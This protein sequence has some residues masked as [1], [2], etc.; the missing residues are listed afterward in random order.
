MASAP[1]TKILSCSPEALHSRP[2]QESTRTRCSRGEIER[3][4]PD[5]TGFKSDVRRSRRHDLVGSDGGGDH[6]VDLAGVQRVIREGRL[7]R[8]DAQIGG[9][10]TGGTTWRSRMPVRWR[11]HSSVVSRVNASSSLVITLSGA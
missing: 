4:R 10:M 8:R 9:G 1:T 6:H 11:T 5:T 2:G 7:G 3:G